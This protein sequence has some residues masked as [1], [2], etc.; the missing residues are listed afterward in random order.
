[1]TEWLVAASLV[2]GNSGSPIVYMPKYGETGRPFLL[3]VQSISVGNANTGPADV[4]GMAP[5]R[6]LV[7]RLREIQMPD[8]NLSIPGDAD[9]ARATTTSAQ[10]KLDVKP[11][12]IAK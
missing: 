6:Y 8:L 1:M 10:P 3:G 12:S 11:I 7:D 4:A 2:G 9:D 5:I